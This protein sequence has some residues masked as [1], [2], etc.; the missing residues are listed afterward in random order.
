[1]ILEKP[2]CALKIDGISTEADTW[3]G[4]RVLQNQLISVGWPCIGFTSSAGWQKRSSS[5]AFFE[6]YGADCRRVLQLPPPFHTTLLIGASQA[7]L[8][9]QVKRKAV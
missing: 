7:F 9:R 2:P 1:M 4:Y 5:Q 3:K 8:D 6:S